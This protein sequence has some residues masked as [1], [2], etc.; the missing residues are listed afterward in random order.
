MT[1]HLRTVS[2]ITF[3]MAI[4]SL[5]FGVILFGRGSGQVKAATDDQI[6]EEILNIAVLVKNGTA[7]AAKIQAKVLASRIDDLDDVMDVLKPR[8]KGGLGVGMPGDVVPDGIEH[9]LI[10]LGRQAPGAAVLAKHADALEEMAY[11]VAAVSEVAMAKPPVKFN[12]KQTKKDWVAWSQ[13]VR[14]GSVEFAKA[15]KAKRPQDVQN[16]ANKINAA[17]NNCHSVFR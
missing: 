11:I 12:A 6:N 2:P 7:G 5:S 17:C 9:M 14:D 16:A 4:L 1:R 15:A 8:K 10:T 3:G 13:D